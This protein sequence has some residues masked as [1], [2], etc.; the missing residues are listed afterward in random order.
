ML[1]MLERKGKML[2]K[3]KKESANSNK[4]HDDMLEINKERG[5]RLAE[6]RNMRGYTQRALEHEA[7][8]GSTEKVQG[9]YIYMFE[10]GIRPITWSKAKIF[11]DILNVNPAYIM[12]ESPYM[13]K[14]YSQNNKTLDY[15]EYGLCDTM[16][17]KFLI[18]SGHNIIFHVV[19]LNDGKQPQKKVFHDK[20]FYDWASL[21][22]DVSIDEFETF[23]LSDTH[24]KLCTHFNADVI[25]QSVTVDGYKMPYSLFVFTTKRLYD[26]MNF[27]FKSLKEFKIDY[28]ILSCGDDLTQKEIEY[29]RKTKGGVLP[30]GLTPEENMIQVTKDLPHVSV[31]IGDETT[32]NVYLETEEQTERFL[33]A[34]KNLPPY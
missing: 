4:K 12:A 26:Y 30:N 34:L 8:F 22:I 31:K 10:H 33:N 3:N 24:C 11:G 5:K 14:G 13:N 18:A 20:E 21:Q 2:M 15:D 9:K 32:D 25:I 16:F 1:F 19:D 17:V 7:K 28:D 29:S 23:C 27:T 6:C